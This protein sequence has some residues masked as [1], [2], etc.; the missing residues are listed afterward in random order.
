[1]D[2]SE[3]LWPQASAAAVQLLKPIQVRNL[4][5]ACTIK[6]TPVQLAS[7][8]AR[9]P[10]ALP[11]KIVMQSQADPARSPLQ[12]LLY[13]ELASYTGVKLDFQSK[14]KL[15]S[16]VKVRFGPVLAL[17]SLNLELDFK[18]RRVMRVRHSGCL[19][20]ESGI[21]F[22]NGISQLSS[23]V[24]IRRVLDPL[25]T[26][27]SS[28][29]SMQPP[30]P[31]GLCLPCLPS[32]WASLVGQVMAR[33]SCALGSQIP[34]LPPPSTGTGTGMWLP[35][36]TGFRP[37]HS[38]SPRVGIPHAAHEPDTQHVDEAP[39]R[40]PRL[41]LK[42]HTRWEAWQQH[43]GRPAVRIHHWFEFLKC[44]SIHCMD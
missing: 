23:V 21:D 29:T 31:T 24:H 33:A 22:V 28:S 12:A 11:I 7:L 34:S 17:L 25:S 32:P 16:G 3:V 13:K 30:M 26:L 5:P 20:S 43:A 6:P 40:M 2:A 42:C 4:F 14:P 39:S 19:E 8:E 37:P 10:I 27:S 38:P 35:T 1:M 36:P 15:F 18:N 9:G 44:L 41:D